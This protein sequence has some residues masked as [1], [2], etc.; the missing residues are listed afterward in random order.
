MQYCLCILA[1]YNILYYSSMLNIRCVLVKP[2]V[3][4]SKMEIEKSTKLTNGLTSLTCSYC[5]MVSEYCKQ[6]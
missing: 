4:G 1:M 6:E 3:N 5:L 2:D